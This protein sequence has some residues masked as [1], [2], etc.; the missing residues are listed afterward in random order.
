[1]T[2]VG[3]VDLGI[4]V[5]KGVV[6]KFIQA[7]IGFVG[8]I[9]FARILGPVQFGGFYLLLSIVQIID[10]P[11]IGGWALATKKRFAEV[12]TSAEAMVGSQVL[13][14]VGTI[15]LVTIGA[16]LLREKLASYTGL[17]NVV[18]LLLVLFVPIVFFYPFQNLVVARG[19]VG[20]QVGIDTVRSV[21]TFPLQLGFVLLGLG[22]AGMAYGLGAATLLSLPLTYYSLRTRP[23]LPSREEI[24]SLWAFARHSIP[25][26]L[27]SKV[28]DRYDVLLL[29]L[30][31][32]PAAAGHYEVAFKL[33]LPAMFVATIAGS[34]LM[35]KVSN[36]RSRAEPVA[37]E[38]TN[39]LAFTS[40]LSI[41]IFFGAI[42][43]PRELIVTAYGPAYREAAVLLGGL[44]LFR[45]LRTQSQPLQSAIDGIDRPD[46]NL[47]IS[48]FTL[49]LNV[50]AGYLLVLEHGAVGVVIA[51]VGAEALR[52]S[53][54]SVTLKHE[55]DQFDLLPRPILMQLLAGGFMFLVV[56][57]LA[58]IVPIRSWVDLVL[59]VG[60]GGLS[61]SFSLLMISHQ[62][63]ALAQ[64][65]GA[66]AYVSIRS[67]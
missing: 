14:N 66:V 29:G 37:Q 50:V 11:V 40:I 13:F 2:D 16:F 27:V 36:L 38:V 10:K 28:F 56:S 64:K 6:A 39:A 20:R 54:C 12:D 7:A 53:L 48:A 31:L 33:T 42:A 34:A 19:M 51:T 43:I 5:S 65:V 22:A 3:E 62:V 55:L 41:P 9:L 35:P 18:F 45:L 58:L 52:Y 4:E 47:H 49:A 15:G 61:Y 46:V 63:R 30:L 59:V 57:G 32:G 24:A 17:E 26:S 21:L 67:V 1:M 60:I 25:T 23:A 8:I 44:A